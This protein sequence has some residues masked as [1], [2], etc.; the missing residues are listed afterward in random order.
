MDFIWQ[1]RT[2]GENH[3]LSDDVNTLA[4][5]VIEGIQKAENA[6]NSSNNAI[7]KAEEAYALAQ[8]AKEKALLCGVQSDWNEEDTVALS[9][10]KNR[11]FYSIPANGE[12]LIEKKFSHTIPANDWVIIDEGGDISKYGIETSEQQITGPEFVGYTHFKVVWNGT[13]YNVS[14]SD[15]SGDVALY[16]AD[17]KTGNH[18]QIYTHS[19]GNGI[20]GFMVSLPYAK[21]IPTEPITLEIIP[22][23]G[24]LEEQI[25]QLDTK[26]I[27]DYVSKTYVDSTITHRCIP[28]YGEKT[29]FDLS[30][31]WEGGAN[32]YSISTENHVSF[33]T[34]KQ[35]AVV[36]NGETYICTATETYQE[37]QDYYVYSIKNEKY[38]KEE[39]GGFLMGW[40]PKYGVFDIFFYGYTES[41][42][43]MPYSEV[44]EQLDTKYI[45]DYIS[46]TEVTEMVGDIDAALDG[47]IAMQNELIGGG[48]V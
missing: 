33:E 48:A 41:C 3:V 6:Q 32:N 18:V 43:V 40:T 44:V 24:A 17:T 47:I 16:L 11:P 45:P 2:D 25:K 8:E 23:T 19:Y 38:D 7:Q 29:V 22:A 10:I 31:A 30:D 39:T 26:Y 35:Y 1:P 37:S 36:W 46:K 42:E 12:L 27:P 4:D 21:S 5:G 15:V 13:E 34:G 28:I 20:W 9:H 14:D